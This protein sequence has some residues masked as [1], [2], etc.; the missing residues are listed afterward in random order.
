MGQAALVT[1]GCPQ[2]TDVEMARVEGVPFAGHT[3]PFDLP[4]GGDRAQVLLEILG[5][6]Q[7][8]VV[9]ADQLAKRSEYST[10]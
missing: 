8:L 4:M 3:A 6:V 9:D 10:L 5:K 2:F 7:Q 1:Q